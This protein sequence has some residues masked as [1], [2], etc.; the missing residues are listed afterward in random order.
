MSLKDAHMCEN[1][2]GFGN[3]L[4]CAGK[5]NPIFFRA[6]NFPGPQAP[7]VQVPSTP[8]QSLNVTMSDIDVRNSAYHSDNMYSILSPLA[9]G[10]SFSPRDAPGVA[11]PLSQ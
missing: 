10:A 2:N 11:L 4:A 3:A 8:V 5:P 1:T 9:A 7:P 6:A